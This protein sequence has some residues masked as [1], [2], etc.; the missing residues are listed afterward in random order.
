MQK[1]HAA[2]WFGARSGHVRAGAAGTGNLVGTFQTRVSVPKPSH[3][4]AHLLCWGWLDGWSAPETW[5]QPPA[6]REWDFQGR[7]ADGWGLWLA[8]WLVAF[9]CLCGVF[10]I[11]AFLPLCVLRSTASSLPCSYP[12]PPIEASRGIL[13]RDAAAPASS[14]V[15]LPGRLATTGLWP[16][17][18]A[19]L[20]SSGG[21]KK[22]RRDRG[23]HGEYRDRGVSGL[24]ECSSHVE[25]QGSC[26]QWPPQL[27]PVRTVSL[28]GGTSVGEKVISGKDGCAPLR[29]ICREDIIRLVDDDGLVG[30]CGMGWGETEASGLVWDEIQSSVA[31]GPRMGQRRKQTWNSAVS[32]PTC[33]SGSGYAEHD[34]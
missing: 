23:C 22:N 25:E 2:R 7:S 15:D 21:A 3:A 27:R 19:M 17:I 26:L 10:C 11:S 4:Q 9:V 14:S 12:P 1:K 33:Q 30:C 13:H 34:A 18:V 6:G 16:R 8:G 29:K 24:P 32:S 5:R 20:V 31:A 28:R